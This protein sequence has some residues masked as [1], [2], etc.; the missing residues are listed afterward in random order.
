MERGDK[1]LL[2]LDRP[3]QP[4]RISKM[5]AA[6]IDMQNASLLPWELDYQKP[7]GFGRDG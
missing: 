3:K 4:D 6:G 2:I 5:G 1:A 7:G